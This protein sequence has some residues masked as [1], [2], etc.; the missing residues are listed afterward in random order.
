MLRYTTEPDAAGRRT[1]VCDDCG[2]TRNTHWPLERVHHVCAVLAGPESLITPDELTALKSAD[3]PLT[4]PTLVGNR[5]ESLFKEVGIP[6]CGGCGKRRDWLNVAHLWLRS[7]AEYAARREKFRGDALSL[8]SVGI[9]SA[10]DISD[11]MS[12]EPA[13]VT[14]WLK[15]MHREGLIAEVVMGDS[16]LYGLPAGV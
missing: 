2:Y 7:P 13:A 12:L 9:F 14:H 11:R 6:T 5:L 8:F 16:R 15:Q 1:I 10:A 3:Q 4:D